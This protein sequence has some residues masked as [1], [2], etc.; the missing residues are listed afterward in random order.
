MELE[1]TVRFARASDHT[2]KNALIYS[3]ASRMTDGAFD[4]NNFVLQAYALKMLDIE[5]RAA[6]QRV[7]DHLKSEGL[8]KESFIAPQNDVGDSKP[9]TV[10]PRSESSSSASA[11]V[12][13]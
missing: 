9:L 7:N 1:A 13:G 6:V 11:R 5:L 3:A 4:N 10:G 12:S 2:A 8:T